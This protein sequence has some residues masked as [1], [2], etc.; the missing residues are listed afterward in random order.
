MSIR[1]TNGAGGLWASLLSLILR[2]G[3]EPDQEDTRTRSWARQLTSRSD[4]PQPYL[5]FFDSL[6][7]NHGQPSPYMVLTPTFR[8]G[9]GRPE[10]E[11]LLCAIGDTIHVVETIDGQLHSTSYIPQDVIC[12]ER[13]AILLHAWITIR[14]HAAGRGTEST[15]VRF[16]SVTDHIMLPFVERLRPTPT[17]GGAADLEMERARF[18]DLAR[19]HFKFMSYGQ[20]TIRPGARV[21]KILLQPQIRREL[22]GLLG[23]SL[24]RLIGPAH[25]TILT[26]SELILIRDDVSQRWSRRSP[27][28]AIWTYIPRAKILDV[29]V[30]PGNDDVQVF[31]IALPGPFRIQAL[32]ESSQAADLA[33]LISD[34]KS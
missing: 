21:N 22:I 8:G 33:R 30:T 27:H 13:G 26:D 31:T 3:D 28:G 12:L 34:L 29:S 14:G 19:T 18:N 32:F 10:H 15:T 6:P 20:G 24:S 17:A 4:L 9:Y 2:E 7:P 16:N 5:A 1:R 25:L 23:F 11:R